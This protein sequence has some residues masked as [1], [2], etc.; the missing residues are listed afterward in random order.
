MVKEVVLKYF[1]LMNRV[2]CLKE[3]IRP[4]QKKLSQ[5]RLVKEKLN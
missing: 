5:R 1:C 3:K 4:T 2:V